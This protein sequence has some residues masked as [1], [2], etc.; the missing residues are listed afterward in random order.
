MNTLQIDVAVPDVEQP[1]HIDTILSKWREERVP[2]TYEDLLR[3]K[4]EQQVGSKISPA[5]ASA[6]ISSLRAALV[7]CEDARK[8]QILTIENLKG[9]S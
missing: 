1:A 4:S 5:R 8:A 3:V 9:A 6:V 7:E 2:P